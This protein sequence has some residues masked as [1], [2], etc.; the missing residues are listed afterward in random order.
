MGPLEGS[1]K[2]GM[3]W[4]ACAH[5]EAPECQ[6]LATW[7]AGMQPWAALSTAGHAPGFFCQALETPHCPIK[8]PL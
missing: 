7:A 4:M 2:S 3:A 8:G 5:V 1:V 6:S